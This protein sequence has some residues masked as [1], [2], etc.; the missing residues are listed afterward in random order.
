MTVAPAVQ[1]R[2]V[3]I[4][5]RGLPHPQGSMLTHVMPTG[6]V[7]TRYPASVWRWRA[8][9]QQAVADARVTQI[10]AP[11]EL[12]LGFDLPRPAG[13]YGTGRNA[14]N[15]KP[16][17]PLWPSIRPDL[18]KLVRCICDAITDAGLWRSDAQ[19][20]SLHSAKRYTNQASDVPGVR[21]TIT[22]LTT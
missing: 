1:A 5:V 18:D 4:D 11:V 9:V 2:S 19:V 21:I 16:S 20:C 3:T 6:K 13:H 17:A 12:R 14:G 7:A 22:E 15:V 10:T 8:Q